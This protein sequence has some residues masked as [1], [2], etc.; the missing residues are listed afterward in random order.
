MT[1]ETKYKGRGDTRYEL[2]ILKELRNAVRSIESKVEDILDELRGHSLSGN[3]NG[4]APPE[5]YDNSEY[6]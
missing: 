6:E 3:S 4:F 2:Q 1:S 5:L